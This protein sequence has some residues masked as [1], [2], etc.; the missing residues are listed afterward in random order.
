M[1]DVVCLLEKAVRSQRSFS[2]TVV[3]KPFGRGSKSEHNAV[4]LVTSDG[5]FVLRRA[6]GNPF[7]D[8]GLEK[9]VGKRI[10]CTGHLVGGYTLVISD[11][12]DQ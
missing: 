11:W 3:R 9:L 2:G 10:E 6:G 7:S 5:E 4:W 12:K 1:A 8:P